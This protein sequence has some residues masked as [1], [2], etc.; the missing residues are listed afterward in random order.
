MHRTAVWSR[1]GHCCALYRVGPLIWRP[2]IPTIAG[3]L[4][5]TA[6]RVPSREAL[7]FGEVRLTYAE[8]DAEVDRVAAVLLEDGLGKGQ[9]LAL[10]STNTDWFVIALYA[11]QRVGAVVVPVNPAS[12]APEID[13]ILGTPGR[14]CWSSRLRSVPPCAMLWLPVARPPAARDSH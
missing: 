4:L 13:Y 6:A 2:F 9:R 7:V 1:V 5:A 3:T 11:A 14:R 12:A 8:L 10:K